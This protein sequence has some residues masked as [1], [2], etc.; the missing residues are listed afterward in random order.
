LKRVIVKYG[1]NYEGTE[2][3]SFYILILIN[4]DKI[5]ELIEQGLDDEN[6]FLTKLNVNSNNKI[7]VVIDGDNGVTIKQCAD[8]SKYIEKNLD[9]DEEDFS[10]EVSSFGLGEDYVSKR[11]YFKNQG[12]S[13]VVIDS[14]DKKHKGIMTE[15]TD[16]YIII[17]RKLTKMQKKDRV[18]PIFKIS[19]SEIKSAKTEIVI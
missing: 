1:K 15:V 7:V 16:D 6:L 11:Q 12:K 9:R 10:L 4:K 8:L 5:L 17:D 14:N 13:V 3:P 2:V 18:E 19:F